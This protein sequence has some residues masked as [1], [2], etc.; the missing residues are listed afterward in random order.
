MSFLLTAPVNCTWGP[1]TIGACSQTCGGGTRVKSRTKTIQEAN[2]GT[3]NGQPT[4]VEYC[5]TNKCGTTGTTFDRGK[6][7][8]KFY[9]H[10]SLIL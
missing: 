4:I 8:K 10:P 5:N 1:W 9:K 2:G 3:C 6:S 7:P